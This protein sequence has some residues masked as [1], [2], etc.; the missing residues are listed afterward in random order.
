[1]GNKFNEKE[2]INLCETYEEVKKSGIEKVPDV[3]LRQ[4]NHIVRDPNIKLLMSKESLRK[5]HDIL[6]KDLFTKHVRK[7]IIATQSGDLNESN[8]TFPFDIPK[9]IKQEDIFRISSY[10]GRKLKKDMDFRKH[11]LDAFENDLKESKKVGKDYLKIYHDGESL[12]SDVL[13]VLTPD[14]N[15]FKR[16]ISQINKALNLEDNHKAG[17]ILLS[18]EFFSNLKKQ[19]H[20]RNDLNKRLN[21]K[22]SKT[23]LSMNF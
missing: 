13:G 3:I 9:E 15:L 8:K 22:N 23:T 20:I 19:Y 2:F 6:G 1:M 4:I 16:T 7:P 5:A 14:V 10:I 17:K 11:L 21:R 12:N 18:T